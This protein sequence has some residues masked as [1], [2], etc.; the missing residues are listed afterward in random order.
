LPSKGKDCTFGEALK[1]F[2]EVDRLTKDNKYKCPVCKSLQNATKRLSVNVA[3][4]ILIVTIKR[5]DM[6]GQK[7]TKYIRYPSM[8]K[9]KTYMDEFVD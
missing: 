6:F 1:Q 9:M 8:F 2:F 4:R 3:P 5:F 7:I